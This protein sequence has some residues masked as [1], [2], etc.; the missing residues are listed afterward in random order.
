MSQ[1]LSYAL[2]KSN[3]IRLINAVVKPQPRQRIPN[4]ECHRQG[5]QI[6]ISVMDFNIAVNKK[7]ELIKASILFF[8]I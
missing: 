8:D 1:L 5:M 6:S 3:L 2:F 4:I 7:Y